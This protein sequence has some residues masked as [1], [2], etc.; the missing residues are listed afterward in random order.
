MAT[1]QHTR[2]RGVLKVPLYIRALVLI[3][4]LIL[5]IY[6]WVSD[7]SLWRILSEFQAKYILSGE[8]HVMLN[9]AICYLA[10]VGTAF[11]LLLLLS[12]FFKGDS[13]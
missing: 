3:T 4:A 12:L 7:T 8:Y 10:T 2:K 13:T 11:L 1:I 9:V 6:W 5:P